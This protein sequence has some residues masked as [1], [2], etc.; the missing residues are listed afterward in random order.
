MAVNDM[1]NSLKNPHP[2]IP[3]SHIRDD[4]IAAPTK[5]AEIFNFF[6][7]KVKLKDFQMHLP[8]SLKHNPRQHI[9]PNLGLARAPKVPNKITNNN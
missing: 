4:T 8:R 7:K 5:L 2:E 6:F 9:P 3:F 1:S